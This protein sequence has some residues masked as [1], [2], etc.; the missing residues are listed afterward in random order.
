MARW[1][2]STRRAS[3]SCVR[4]WLFPFQ[5]FLSTFTLTYE[6]MDGSK[7][8]KN[9]RNLVNKAVKWSPLCR[10]VLCF[11]VG[12]KK[13]KTILTN[14]N[15]FTNRSAGRPCLTDGR[16]SLQTSP[17]GHSPPKIH[18]THQN[19]M[20]PTMMLLP[21]WCRRVVGLLMIASF[22]LAQDYPGDYPDYQDYAHSDD[23][24]YHNYAQHQQEKG[25]G[26]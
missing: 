6:L 10:A 11:F 7:G 19:C 21:R 9:R 15:L 3:E 22:V 14:R 12:V 2:H 8:R 18:L 1:H 26:G 17:R 16:K 23:N 5:I 20:S 4:K 25:Q 13:V 24:L